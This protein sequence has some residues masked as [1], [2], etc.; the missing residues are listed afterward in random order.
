MSHLRSL[1]A[2]GALLAAVM[3]IA[4]VAAQA[5]PAPT[6]WEPTLVRS[7]SFD[8]ASPVEGTV[9]RE[10][11]TT[12][13]DAPWMRLYFSNARLDGDSYLR[14]VSVKDGAVMTMHA[15]HLRQWENSSAYFNGNA[16]MIELVAGPYTSGN[17]VEMTRYLIGNPDA[18]RQQNDT[19]CGT[20]DNRV[21]SSD[22]RAGRIDGI[23]CTGWIINTSGIDKV[24]L[25]AGH[26]RANNQVL[27]FGVPSSSSNCGLQFPPP[28]QQFAIDTAGS[29]SA[30]TGI[31]NDYWVFKCFP[32]STTGLTTFETQ[33]A[34]F[35]LAT[36]MPTAGNTTRVTGYGL[37]GTSANNAGGNNGSCTCTPSNGT[38]SRNQTQQTHTGPSVSFSGTTA[39]Y[40]VDTCG[41][42]SGSPV[43][44]EATGRAFAIHT[45]GGCSTTAGSANSGTQVTNAGLQTAIGTL[46]QGCARYIPDSGTTGTGNV[47]PLGSTDST[48]LTT[49][50][51][52]NNGGSNGGAVYFDLTLNQNTHWTGIDVNTSAA[53]GTALIVDVYR[54][55]TTYVGN[56]ANPAAWTPVTTGHGIAAGNDLP[57]RIQFN[58]PQF[59]TAGPRGIAI[60]ARNFNHR[61]TNGTGSNQAY[62]D[63]YV[64]LSLGAASNAPFGSTIS[65]RVANVTIRYNLDDSTWTNQIYQTIIRR[66]ELLTAGPISNLA[67][68]CTQDA[69]HFN[70]QLRIRMSHVPAGHVMS[71]TFA[72]NMPSPVT[73]MDKWDYT[74][75]TAANDWAE[76]GFSTPFNYNGTSDV[77]VEIYARGN[78]ST[79]FPNAAGR[80]DFNSGPQERLF[81]YGWAFGGTPATGTY[82]ASSGLRM[83]VNYN[84]ATF[85]EYGTSCGSLRTAFFSTPNRGGFAWYDL[86]GAPANG[87]VI[88][89]MGFNATTF[90]TSLSNYGFT[91]CNVYHDLTVSTFKFADSLGSTY[92]GFS[93]PNDPIFDGL[94]VH[95]QWFALDATQ[96]GGITASNYIT[97]LIGIDP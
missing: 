38:G 52:S 22:A 65:P 50:F 1:R 86:N 37:D 3:P 8:N 74:W 32:N 92:H 77:V 88:I 40:T 54:C 39:T 85:G 9:W 79:G 46:G 56:A 17:S 53:A 61:Y 66:S 24:H 97:N 47:I 59:W 95:G 94:R 2:H 84:C 91:N 26:C 12:R 11:V 29:V 27:S 68:S 13:N 4:S 73:V 42:N 57:S 45:N 49:V 41:G 90:P 82:N 18:P 60:V 21:P 35:T 76:V 71:T 34:A 20:T 19:I 96:A 72:N 83:R 7:G 43:I 25:S 16:V 15:E 78:T 48:G 80:V 67:F 64:G 70:R 44:D 93:V 36:T 62:S 55:N 89:A 69:R 51:T 23:G 87:G 58:E 31:G 10:F 30:N 6:L 5:A 63:A 81:A 75:H 14:I 28:S 33:N